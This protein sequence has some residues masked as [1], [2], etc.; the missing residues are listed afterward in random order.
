MTKKT[1]TIDVGARESLDG[2]EM[3]VSVKYGSL[4]T[5]FDIWKVWGYRKYYPKK[6]T[7]WYNTFKIYINPMRKSLYNLYGIVWK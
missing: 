4:G 2:S 6:T 3:I 5:P 7:E 1:F